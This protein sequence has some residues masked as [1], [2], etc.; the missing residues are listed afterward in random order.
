[1][2][3]LFTIHQGEYLVGAHIE[4]HVNGPDNQK[5]NVWI[6][7]KDTGVDILVTDASNK[8]T[9]ALQVK[10]SKD[11]LVTHFSNE[12]QERLL[13][14]GWWTL[15]RDKIVQSTADFWVFV[16]YSFSKVVSSA[17]QNSRGKNDIQYIIVRP[18]ELISRLDQIHGS[19]K[20]LQTYLWVTREKQRRC[21]EA[22]GLKK[23]NSRSMVLGEEKVP[24][25][26][27]FSQYLNNWD[28]IFA[29]W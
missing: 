28:A 3:P 9:V 15:N 2:K 13:C 1:M 27:D 25:E 19:P 12:M 20:S 4:Q 24:E 21:I 8:K 17:I 29:D 7:S 11:F 22:R 14:C 16:L 26:R 10:F 18:D 6:P 5:V 23:N